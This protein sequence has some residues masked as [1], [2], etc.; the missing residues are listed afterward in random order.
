MTP[1][2]ELE[3]IV[4]QMDCGAFTNSS[5]IVLLCRDQES[6]IVTVCR[7][8]DQTNLLREAWEFKRGNA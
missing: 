5:E 4:Q 3:K 1:E 2:K 6:G 7:F 8:G